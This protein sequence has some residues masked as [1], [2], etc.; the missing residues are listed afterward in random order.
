MLPGGILRKLIRRSTRFPGVSLN[1]PRPLTVR[2]DTTNRC[3]LRC[4]MCP[5]RLSGSDP[6]RVW[7]DMDRGLF[8]RIA[9]QVFPKAGS[10]ALSCGAEPLC[11]PSFPECLETL[12]RADVPCRE[13][14]TN[15]LLL[16]GE[17]LEAV[18]AFPPTSLTV[19]IDG[20][21]LPTQAAIR[22]GCDLGR[23][24]ENLGGLAREKARRRQRMPLVSFSTTLQR[25]NI[26]ELPGIVRLASTCGAAAVNANF[27]VP[28]EGLEM[29][30]EVIDPADPS[31]ISTIA[32]SVAIAGDLGLSL[33]MTG[34]ASLVET[35]RYLGSWV[36]I[37]PDGLVFPCP[38]WNLR[39]PMGDLS[40][41]S[42]DEVWRGERFED[43]RS[44][45]S[46]GRFEGVCGSCPELAYSVRG[47]IRKI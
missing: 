19:S 26:D 27:L 37:A 17:M 24:V 29:S 41:Q 9:S 28:Y 1:L 14:V 22:G 39:D 44:R 40:R 33:N 21:S 13:M 3:N 2:M 5:M 16:S 31:T 11:N 47:E 45:V 30:G 38:Y 46:S 7:M 36:F 23:V 15:G 32:G 8:T 18:L 35:C 25:R 6:G 42:F 12:Y 4:S 34:S 10:V 43:L 20:A